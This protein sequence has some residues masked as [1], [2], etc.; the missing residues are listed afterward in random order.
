MSMRELEDALDALY[1]RYNNNIEDNNNNNQ[2]DDSFLS[3]I[4]QVLYALYTYIHVTTIQFSTV[5]LDQQEKFLDVLERPKY[6]TF[7]KFSI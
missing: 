5:I 2:S 7:E 6:T 4:F 1:Q 3:S